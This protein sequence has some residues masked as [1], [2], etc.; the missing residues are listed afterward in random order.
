MSDSWGADLLNGFD[1][2][3]CRTIVAQA[4]G[5]NYSALQMEFRRAS[6]GAY[7]QGNNEK[8][9]VYRLLSQACSLCLA[10]ESASA[11]FVPFAVF[12]D[13]R[14]AG[15]EDFAETELAFFAQIAPSITEALIRARLF[16]LAWTY[17]TPKSVSYAHM[18]IDAYCEIPLT[19]EGWNY[20]GRRCWRRAF[21]L[22]LMIGRE[23]K[24]HARKIEKRI[25]SAFQGVTAEEYGYF[26]LWLADI[27]TEFGFGQSSAQSIAEKLEGH[28]RYFEGQGDL[29]AAQ[30]YYEGA[31]VWHKKTEIMK[32]VAEVTY[33]LAE[34]YASEAAA[35]LNDRRGAFAARSFYEKAIQVLRQIPSNE[36]GLFDAN[37][38]IAEHRKM[39]GTLGGEALQE[40]HL[41][42]IKSIDI[43]P[44]VTRSKKDVSQKNR[45]DALRSFANISP[46][47]RHA[48]LV[49][50]AR[51]MANEY[52]LSVVF[53]SVN[54]S[55]DGRVVAKTPGLGLSGASDAGHDA[56]HVLVMRNYT[57]F[58]VPLVVQGRVLPA[59]DVLY[60]E[61]RISETDFRELA[62]YSPVVMPG[63]EPLWSRGLF[64]G[65][66][67]DFAVAVHLLVPQIEHLVRCHLKAA[68]VTTTS[69]DGEGIEMELGLSALLKR[70]EVEKIFGVDPTF[71]MRSLL[72]DPLGANLRNELAHGLAEFAACHSAHAVYVWWFALKLVFNSFW[73]LA[74]QRAGQTRNDGKS[75]GDAPAGDGAAPEVV[76]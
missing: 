43:S 70:Q 49:A 28:G 71:E 1:V 18:A 19:P 72:C 36:R 16:D 29:T 13:R 33:A 7:S 35:C 22:A 2:D 56:I 41:F 50:E 37:T 11:P 48:D 76:P 52:P 21:R 9:N 44:L 42:E 64:A 66:D 5:Q 10:P 59:L 57:S 68:G 58:H 62:T 3:E 53:P 31:I 40:M 12:P 63:R 32:K 27:L 46:F 69:L 17:L 34:T 30:S 26:P 24:T 45:I 47:V 15:A 75:Q 55:R 61:H 38:R 23:A 6:E 39:M 60:M 67:G 54:M 65:Y 74:T 4:S 8:A 73:H 25:V 14:S 51:K 20:D